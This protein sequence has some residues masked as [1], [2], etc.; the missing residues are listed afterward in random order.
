MAGICSY[1]GYVPR[2][3][4]NR[5]TIVQAMAWMNMAIMAHAQGEKAVANFDEDPITMAVAAGIDA[6]KGI[7]RSTIEGVYFAST[8]MPYIERLNAGIIIPALNV[9][10]Q[11]R[12]ADFSGGLKSST[13]ALLSAL[14]GVGSGMLNNVLITSA[15]CRLGMAATNQEMIFGDAAAAFVVGDKDVIAEFKGSYS[16][17]YDFCDHVRSKD[18]DMDRQWEERWIRNEGYAR[19]IPEAI[20]GLLEKCQ[21]KITDFA[22]VIYPCHNRGARKDINKKLSIPPEI[23]QSNLQAEIGDSGTSLPLVMLAQALEGA[24]PGDKILVASYGSGADALYFEVTENIQNKKGNLGISGYLAKKED[25]GS[26]TKYAVWRDLL[27]ADVGMR[28]EVADYTAFSM[29]WRRRKEILGLWGTQCTNCGTPQWPPQRICANPECGAMNKMEPYSFSEKTG[30]IISFTGDMLAAGLNPP[31]L[32]GRI[33]FEGGGRNMF[34]FT[35]C[36]LEELSAGKAMT[37]TFRLKYKDKT[38]NIIGYYWKA[39]PLQEVG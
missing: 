20:N 31:S 1:G 16:V 4:L 23:E 8:T 30:H 22:K 27:S 32:G 28:N 9:K 3:R 25:L 33:E 39:T 29:L 2:Y 14:E 37:M 15:D 5:D 38:R 19:F 10:D 34:D 12:G 17:T 6:L 36:T 7:D 21:L 18:S 35:D 11:V 26:Y 13:T 24:K